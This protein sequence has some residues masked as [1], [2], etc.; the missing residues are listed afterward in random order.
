ML[1]SYLSVDQLSKACIENRYFILRTPSGATMAINTGVFN[2]ALRK[3]QERYKTKLRTKF[4]SF[5]PCSFQ[6]YITY[7][8]PFIS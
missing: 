5:R 2:L 6:N 8:K 7:K 4:I 1:T 3:A